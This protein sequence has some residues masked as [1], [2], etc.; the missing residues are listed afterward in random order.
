MTSFLKIVSLGVL[1]FMKNYTMYLLFYKFICHLI[2]KSLF[3]NTYNHYNR[4][5]RN[6]DTPKPNFCVYYEWDKISRSNI[7]V[8]S[9][10][11]GNN[12]WLKASF[13]FL[14]DCIVSSLKIFSR[15]GRAHWRYWQ[16]RHHSRRLCQHWH[17]CKC[18]LAIQFDR[19]TR[20]I[21]GRWPSMIQST[22]L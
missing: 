15:H 3:L 19:H 17:R 8:K 1:I 14:V 7:A 5:S 20:N 22:D 10:Y 12:C 11:Q 9:Q 2:S 13:I 6:N 4:F 16:L 18:E 21:L